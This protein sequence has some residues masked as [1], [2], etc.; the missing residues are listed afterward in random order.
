MPRVL[1]AFNL[2]LRSCLL[3]IA[4]PMFAAAVALRIVFSFVPTPRPDMTLQADGLVE[5]GTV[6]E[7]ETL[8]EADIVMPDDLLG[9]EVYLVGV[10]AKG[11]GSLP[12][13]T[14]TVTL[15]KNGRRFVE[16]VERPGTTVADT[17]NDYAGATMRTAALGDTEGVMLRPATHNIPCVSQNEKFG[18]PGFCE[19]ERI[20]FFEK[21][22]L[23]MSVAADG[24][25]VTDGELMLLARD[26]IE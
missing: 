26:M 22:G 10:Y 5:T 13:G 25:H 16:I 11:V 20:L 17:V 8:T 12:A 24:P 4:I 2:P 18:L 7:A 6:A 19:I 21:N 9:A 14:A 1:G 3:L 23:V 15:T